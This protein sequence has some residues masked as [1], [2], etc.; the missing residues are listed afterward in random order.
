MENKS[1]YYRLL[2][3]AESIFHGPESLLDDSVVH[4]CS[5]VPGLKINYDLIN[6][7]IKNEFDKK[8][9]FYWSI[10]SLDVVI[11]FILAY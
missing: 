3:L 10:L 4:L 8:P 6:C 11:V 7:K 2:N 9:T 1:F 5:D